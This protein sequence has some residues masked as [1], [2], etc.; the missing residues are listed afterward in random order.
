VFERLG[1]AVVRHPVRVI[2]AWVVAVIALG[3][4]SF[5]VLGPDGPAAVQGSNEADFLPDSYESAQ[6]QKL[7]DK[8]F[9]QPDKAGATAV[10][11][12][13]RVD[14]A[15]LGAAD[16]EKAGETGGRARRRPRRRR[17]GPRDLT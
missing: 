5:A 7:A 9:P 17:R 1:G 8:A 6:A 14:G 13:S 15:A 16:R 12:L 2:L 4:L 11:V 3:G 10:L